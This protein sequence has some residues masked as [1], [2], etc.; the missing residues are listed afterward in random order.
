MSE[1][2]SPDQ[3]PPAAKKPRK[4]LKRLIALAA[5]CL[6]LVMLLRWFEYSQVYHPTTRMDA[7][8]AELGRPFE[9]VRFKASDGVE[10]NG[11][12]YPANTNSPRAHLALLFCHGNGGNIGYGLDIYESLLS[13][14]ISLLTFDYR[15]YGRS[16][17]KPSE[18]GTYLDAEAAYQWLRAK[19]FAATNIILYG[20]SLGGGVATELAMREKTGGLILQS[21]FTSVPD[22]GAELFPWLPVRWLGTIRYDTHSKLPQLKIPVL[23]MHSRADDLI[24]YHHGERN[25]AAANEPKLFWEIHGGHNGA[26]DDRAIF[27]AGIEKFLGDLQR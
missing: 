3:K 20:Q 13:T 25:F 24:P 14:G 6:L 4:A 8:G 2:K 21:T 23:I 7:T 26:G 10:I 1:P 22:I 5:A 11:W 17:G 9:D 18:D 27:V 15:G 19:G 12:F 16:E